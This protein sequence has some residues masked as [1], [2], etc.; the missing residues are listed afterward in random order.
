MFTEAPIETHNHDFSP[1]SSSTS[2]SLTTLNK[3]IERAQSK[4]LSLQHP[5]GYWVFELLS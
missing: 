1:N 5:E 2:Q 4:L 3:A